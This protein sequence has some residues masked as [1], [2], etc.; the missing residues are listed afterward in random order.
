[1]TLIAITAVSTGALVSIFATN[2]FQIVQFIPIVIIPQVFLSGLIPVQ[3]LPAPLA[4]L[5]I[6]TPI[7]HGSV[8]LEKSMLYGESISGIAPQ[9][10][11]LSA[12]LIV[13]FTLNTLSLKAVK[14]L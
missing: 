2:E 6:L 12:I 13:L 1:M 4:K 3:Q 8:A 10:I 11:A 5:P 14:G 9:I 7:Y